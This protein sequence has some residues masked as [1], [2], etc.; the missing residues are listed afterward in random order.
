MKNNNTDT[1]F[2]TALIAGVVIVCVAL[3]VDCLAPCSWLGARSV[4]DAPLRCIGEV[5]P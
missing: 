5:R 4:K 1:L 2:V 3:A